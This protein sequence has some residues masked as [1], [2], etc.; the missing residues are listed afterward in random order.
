MKKQ[1]NFSKKTIK[2]VLE[3][4]FK[5]YAWTLE[6][7]FSTSHKNNFILLL[8]LILFTLGFLKWLAFGTYCFDCLLFLFCEKIQKKNI[9]LLSRTLLYLAIFRNMFLLK[10]NNN[11]ICVILIQLSNFFVMAILGDLSAFW[12]LMQIM[13]IIFGSEHKFSTQKYWYFK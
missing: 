4:I 9:V 6:Y 1:K 8:L 5:N 3:F 11:L 2:R 13:I 10:Y 7:R 12:F